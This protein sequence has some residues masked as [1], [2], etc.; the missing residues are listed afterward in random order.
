MDRRMCDPRPPVRFGRWSASA[1]ASW[2]IVV[3]LTLAV[4]GL[5]SARA[6]A[7]LPF[8]QTPIDYL[9]ATTDDPVARLQRRIERGEAELGFDERRG[10][11]PS[12]LDQL[13]VPRESQV[14]V[15]SKT[16]FQRA[17]ISPNTP[18]AL[19][20]ND[21]TYMLFVDEAPLCET[22]EGTSGFARQFAALGP[23]DRLGRS[24]REFDLSRRLFKYPCSYLIYSEVFEH[25]P[26]PLK[27]YTN[28][29]LREIL[30]NQDQTLDY[31]GLS[32]ADRRAVFEI[33]RDT[34]PGLADAW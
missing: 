14:L 23:R 20:F 11:L 8:E 28:R 30:T 3:W 27:S 16:S 17:K 32:A 5:F 33:L 2:H 18:R 34:K 24:L 6:R 13:A 10:W 19:Y 1:F 29:R 25:L 26:E 15:F 21:E 22:I 12:L 7:E 9:K 31:R 4:S